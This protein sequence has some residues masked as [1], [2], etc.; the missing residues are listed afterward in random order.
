MGILPGK[1]G[2]DKKE[3]NDFF[4]DQFQRAIIPLIPCCLIRSRL[5]K[6]LTVAG[7]EWATFPAFSKRRLEALC[8]Y[9]RQEMIQIVLKAN[10]IYMK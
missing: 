8:Q 2:L 10:L 4:W 9:L 5:K 1:K 6:H 3:V 7:N